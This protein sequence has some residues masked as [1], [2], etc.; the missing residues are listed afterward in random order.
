[1]LSLCMHN[2]EIKDRRVSSS[3]NEQISQDRRINKEDRR[4]AQNQKIRN[5]IDT[6]IRCHDEFISQNFRN[7]DINSKYFSDTALEALGID[8]ELLTE[9]V[10]DFV[11]QIIKNKATFIEY[12]ENE[13]FDKLHDLAHKNLGV[14][15][16]LHIR[17][18]QKFLEILMND[19]TSDDF[20][21]LQCVEALESCVIKLSPRCAYKTYMLMDIKSS[22]SLL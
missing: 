10:D 12:I 11:S 5:S 3:K 18:A 2:I 13:E 16:N 9:L 19:R 8:E 4:N 14:A 6:V 20:Y 17:D 1:M 21:L 15:R 22:L 7:L